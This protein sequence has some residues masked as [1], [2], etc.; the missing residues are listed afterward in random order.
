[1]TPA[2]KP[3]KEKPPA[4]QKEMTSVVKALKSMG[5]DSFIVALSS[6]DLYS[7]HMEHMRGSATSRIV[8][9]LFLQFIDH[10]VSNSEGE[11]REAL[12]KM[13]EEFKAVIKTFNARADKLSLKEM[14]P[15]S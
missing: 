1:M 14:T 13:G 7:T 3:T 2:P 6:G 15:T 11:Y 4:L 10:Q 12:L 8:I 9:S 5:H